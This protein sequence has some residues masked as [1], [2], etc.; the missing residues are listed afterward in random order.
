MDGNNMPTAKLLV[1][2]LGASP[3]FQAFAT[4]PRHTMRLWI[5]VRL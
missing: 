4:V 5:Y 3:I 1:L 2:V